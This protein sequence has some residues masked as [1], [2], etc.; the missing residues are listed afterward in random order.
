MK[1]TMFATVDAHGRTRVLGYLLHF[2]ES[3]AEILWCIKCFHE[4]YKCAPPNSILTDSGA[5]LISAIDAFRMEGQPWS[6]VRHLLCIFHLS[7]NF[8]KH[9]HPLFRGDRHRTME[10]KAQQVLTPCKGLPVLRSE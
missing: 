3:H 4:T 10:G 7:C 5:G 2:E 6:G 1:L 9:V 8:Q